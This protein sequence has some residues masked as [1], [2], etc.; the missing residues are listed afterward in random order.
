MVESLDV[1]SVGFGFVLSQL[2]GF[3]HFGIGLP[4]I[5]KAMSDFVGV[6][7]RLPEF[8]AGSFTTTANHKSHNLARSPAQS[9]PNPALVLAAFHETPDLIKFQDIALLIGDKG[10]LKVW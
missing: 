7:N 3:N 2:F 9:Q 5:G 4:D 8:F 1:I 10:L 6:R